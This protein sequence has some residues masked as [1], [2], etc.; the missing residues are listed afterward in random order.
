MTKRQLQMVAAVMDLERLAKVTARTHV[1]LRM[2]IGKF[3]RQRNVRGINTFC[4]GNTNE[5]CSAG[6]QGGFGTCN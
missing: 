3:S 6:C 1:A 5:H 4:S 2:A